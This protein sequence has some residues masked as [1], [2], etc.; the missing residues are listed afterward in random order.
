MSKKGYDMLGEVLSEYNGKITSVK[1]LPFENIRH[2]VKYEVTQVGEFHGRLSCKG[3]GSNYVQVASDGTSTTKFYGVF[4]TPDGETIF[5]ESGGMGVPLGAG[6][7]KFRTTA[8]LKS[9]AAKLA[10]VN[11]TPIAFEGEGDFSTMEVR[12]TL[13]AW[14]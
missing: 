6:R 12:G 3:M 8:T 14:Q 10:W 2:G 5:M 1:V 11:T 13:Y 7:V 9:T 4:T